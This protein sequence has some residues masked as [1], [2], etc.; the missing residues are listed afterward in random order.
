MEWHQAL[1]MHR[2]ARGL[3]PPDSSD[4]LYPAPGRSSYAQNR[5]DRYLSAH[6]APTGQSDGVDNA[7]DSPVDYSRSLQYKPP[8]DQV[9]MG[10]PPGSVRSRW[11]LSFVRQAPMRCQERC[12]WR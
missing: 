8:P 3:A 7:L 10:V 5:D 4:S 6:A 11:P 12:V 1:E 2:T 9:P